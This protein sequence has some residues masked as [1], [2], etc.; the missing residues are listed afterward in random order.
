MRFKIPQLILVVDDDA[1][2]RGFTESLLTVHGYVVVVAAHGKDA[3]QRLHDRCPD[4]IVLDLNMPVMDGW[5]FRRAQR[6]L[7]DRKCAAV[8]VLLLTGEDD[9]PSHA[10]TLRAVG[11]ISKPFEPDDLLQ[12]VSSV[13][14]Q[15]QARSARGSIGP[16]PGKRPRRRS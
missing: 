13:L 7:V 2:V 8:P 6:D 11:A 12:A 14:A 15:R 16:A 3:M 10:R 4:L 9:A 5:T 1:D